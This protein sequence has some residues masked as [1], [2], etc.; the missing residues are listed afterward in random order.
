MENASGW[1]FGKRLADHV[2]LEVPGHQ[3]LD[4]LGGPLVGHAY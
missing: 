3:S 2:R 1:M 4:V